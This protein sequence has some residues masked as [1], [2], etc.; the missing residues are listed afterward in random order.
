MGRGLL[1]VPLCALLRHAGVGSREQVQPPLPLSRRRSSWG[2][3]RPPGPGGAE[4]RAC[5]SPAAVGAGGGVGGRPP[6]RPR[7]CVGGGGWLGSVGLDSPDL[8]NATDPSIEKFG[9]PGSGAIIGV[10]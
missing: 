3:G 8:K 4:G 7:V 6:A 2:G 1:P 10:V 5:G 9:S